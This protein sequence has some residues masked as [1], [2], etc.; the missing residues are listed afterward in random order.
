MAAGVVTPQERRARYLARVRAEG[1]R[2]RTA[3]EILR[4]VSVSLAGSLATRRLAVS[5]ITLGEAHYG[6]RKRKCGSQR[7]R[8][9]MGF[10]WPRS[11]GGPSSRSRSSAWRCCRPGSGFVGPSLVE[12]LEGRGY[13]SGSQASS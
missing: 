7:A 6:A 13:S 10:P 2:L 8:P 9:R 12:P 5:M 1:R 11:T 3:A 4:R